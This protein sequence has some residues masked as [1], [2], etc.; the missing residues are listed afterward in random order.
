MGRRRR[1]VTLAAEAAP[2]QDLLG[3]CIADLVGGS[4]QR[5]PFTART[6]RVMYDASGLIRKRTAEATSSGVPV[7]SMGIALRICSTGTSGSSMSVSIRPGATQ[8]T[9]I[10]RFAS[11]TAS[12]VAAPMTPALDAL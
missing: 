11:S 1:F 7:R 10:L 8:F 6:C 3:A 9:V 4:Q 12:A 2:A 5:P